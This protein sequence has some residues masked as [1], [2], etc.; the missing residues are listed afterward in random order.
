MA[1]GEEESNP[2]ESQLMN[3][4]SCHGM[5]QLSWHKHLL[6]AELNGS[7]DFELIVTD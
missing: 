2:L 1:M 4:D 3:S 5:R 6:R 7:L